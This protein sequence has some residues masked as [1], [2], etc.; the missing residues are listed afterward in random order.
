MKIH[1]CVV[2]RLRNGPEKELIDDYLHR[3]EKIGRAHGLGPVLVNEVED[4]FFVMDF[5]FFLSFFNC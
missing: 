3:F 5:V 4:T 2:G 1:L